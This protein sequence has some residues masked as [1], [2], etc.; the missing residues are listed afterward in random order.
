[1]NGA[2]TTSLLKVVN[3]AYDDNLDLITSCVIVPDDTVIKQPRKKD[4]SKPPQ[5]ITERFYEALTN[6]AAD[7]AKIRSE[8]FGKPSITEEQWIIQPEK[9]GLLEPLPPADKD[10]AAYRIATNRRSAA[11]SRHKTALIAANWIRC[12]DY[13]VWSIRNEY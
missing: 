3:V 10:K 11:M 6:A 5:P 12:N 13:F 9:C 7:L 1:P 2:Q 8:S 4:R